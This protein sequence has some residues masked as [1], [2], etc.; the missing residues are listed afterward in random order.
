MDTRGLISSSCDSSPYPTSTVTHTLTSHHYVI[1]R[2]SVGGT[3]P[4]LISVPISVSAFSTIGCALVPKIISVRMCEKRSF[5]NSF[6]LVPS[7]SWQSDLF[8]IRFKS[9]TTTA[10]KRATEGRVW[11]TSA[12]Y[13]V[14]KEDQHRDASIVAGAP[15]VVVLVARRT[16]L[17]RGRGG[18]L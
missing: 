18:H 14:P 7:L 2:R 9:E 11:L 4:C 13:G 12:A 8:H 3:L 5:E 16:K 6:A 17:L 15:L 1:S 10:R